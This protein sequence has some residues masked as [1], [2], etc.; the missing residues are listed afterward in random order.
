VEKEMVYLR[1][2]LRRD[3]SGRI[4]EHTTPRAAAHIDGGEYIPKPMQR[5]SFSYW[6]T[7]RPAASQEERENKASEVLLSW[8]HR[9]LVRF[10][11]DTASTAL[12]NEIYVAPTKLLLEFVAGNAHLTPHT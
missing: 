1:K 2:T 6:I 7:K 4:L 12:S 11:A 10:S 9:P 8:R 3:G 5:Y